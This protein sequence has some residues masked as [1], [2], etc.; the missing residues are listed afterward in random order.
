ML[1][2]L[3]PVTCGVAA[4]ASTLAPEYS[5]D[6]RKHVDFA[7]VYIGLKC[8][9]VFVTMKMGMAS[10]FAVSPRLSISPTFAGS[11]CE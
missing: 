1:S 3:L 7:P 10:L 5:T 8:Q 6:L 2:C 4:A 9:S 11:G